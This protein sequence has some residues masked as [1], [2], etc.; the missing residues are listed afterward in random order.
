MAGGEKE[1]YLYSAG[2]LTAISSLRLLGGLGILAGNMVWG[3]S[4]HS[5]A[6]GHLVPVPWPL[7]LSRP[8]KQAAV[9][10][11]VQGGRGI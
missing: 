3:R 4:G 11:V 9:V 8:S 1:I 7:R 5:G 2:P 6:W 10:C